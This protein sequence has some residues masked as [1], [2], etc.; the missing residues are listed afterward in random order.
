MS[1]LVFLSLIFTVL[2]NLT[3]IIVVYFYGKKNINQIFFVL[4]V[5]SLTFWGVN[6]F[7][8]VTA[9]PEQSLF[10]IRS[11][12]FFAAPQT[13]LLYLFISTFAYKAWDFSKWGKYFLVS[14]CFLMML[15]THTP[16]I[17]SSIVIAGNGQVSPQPGL[18]MPLLGGYI[19]IFALLSVYKLVKRYRKSS[20]QERKQWQYLSFGLFWTFLLMLSLNYLAV[21]VFNNTNFVRYGHLYHLPLIVLFSYSLVKHKLMDVKL[22]ASQSLTILLSLFLL[23]KVLTSEDTV[24]LVINMVIFT[25]VVIIS[26]WLVRNINKEIK[27][28]EKLEILTKDLQVANERLKKLDEAKTEFLSITSHQLRTPLSAIKG[29]LSMLQE[30]DFGKMSKKQADIVGILLRN[31]ERLIR[32]INIFLN[33]SRIESG[34]LKINKSL[35]DISRLLDD[36]IKS[37]AIEAGTKHIKIE[38]E[39]NDVPLFQFDMDKMADVLINLIDNAIKYTPIGGWVRVSVKNMEKYV[40]VKVQDNGKGISY[41]ELDQLFQKF[42]RGKDINRVDTTGVGLG[43]YIAKKIIEGHGGNIWAESEG[44][45]KGTTFKFTLPLE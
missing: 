13:F 1:D 4:L 15:L 6:N 28:R 37:L 21:I 2:A 42:K 26:I 36:I 39:E 16:F 34:R 43:L 30:G 45:N 8:S 11:V 18:L 41:E 22:I 44:E 10:W 24:N 35:N 3:L 31:S 32:L 27:Q 14:L 25:V 40:L 5:L 33:I 7:F 38:F 17:F 20:G 9:K 12:M 19:F 23:F 29:Y